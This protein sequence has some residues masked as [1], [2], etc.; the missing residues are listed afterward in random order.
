MMSRSLRTLDG[1]DA[2][3]SSE[4][5]SSTVA[6]RRRCRMSIIWLSRRVRWVSVC[7][8][9]ADGELFRRGRIYSP[10]GSLSS[11]RLVELREKPTDRSVGHKP[12][13]FESSER[14]I[15][16]EFLNCGSQMDVPRWFLFVP[17][18]FRR[19]ESARP[20]VSLQFPEGE[21][22]RSIVL[23]LIL[24][25]VATMARA[26]STATLEGAVTDQ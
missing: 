17:A 20:T 10:C 4:R 23:A 13:Q 5:I 15:R 3:G 12:P 14:D 18:F 8:V 16:F 6:R 1:V 24:T 2:S 11:L 22:M 19:L 21:C 9:M 25:F 26:Q 7:L